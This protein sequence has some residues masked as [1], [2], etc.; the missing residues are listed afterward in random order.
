MFL[1]TDNPS[2]KSSCTA[3]PF[4]SLS[5]PAVRFACQR[6]ILHSSGGRCVSVL[7][8]EPTWCVDAAICNSMSSIIQPG[9][10]G[11]MHIQPSCKRQEMAE[12]TS[13][14]SSGGLVKKPRA[15]R[16]ITPGDSAANLPPPPFGFNPAP[17]PVD[18]MKGW[19][20]QL[21]KPLM[22]FAY[23]A[24]LRDSPVT[25]ALIVCSSEQKIEFWDK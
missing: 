12:N 1:G 2:T 5:P 22:L 15:E 25:H 24:C 17:M 6:T 4:N 9:D 11:D 21:H 7:R 19:F 14:T 8:R 18:L 13:N 16:L 10:P 3:G 23:V 20:C